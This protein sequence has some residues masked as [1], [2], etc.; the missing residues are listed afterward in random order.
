MQPSDSLV[1]VGR[2]YGFP[3]RWPTS[4][5]AKKNEGLPGYRAVLFRACRGRT[6][7]RI[8]ACPRPDYGQTLVAFEQNSAL[9]I[10][11]GIDFEA[12]YPTA[13]TLACLR[14]AGC[15]TA[16]V[17]RL[18][19]GW[20]GSPLA[21]RDSH[22]LDDKRSFKE[23]SHPPIP[24][25]RHRLVALNFLSPAGLSELHLRGAAIEAHLIE[26]LSGGP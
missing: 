4:L 15:V 25:D 21:G 10:R 19:T 11:D 7:R 13:H 3:C 2:G 16:P 6:P 17:A 26:G 14:F 12:A 24:F 8:E 9:G 23:T 1:L 18:A 22:P 5:T 20:V